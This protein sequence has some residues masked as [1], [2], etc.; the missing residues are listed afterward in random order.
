MLF[1]QFSD[2]RTVFNELA[3]EIL[4]L[5]AAA[6]YNGVIQHVVQVLELGNNNTIFKNL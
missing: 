3:S 6:P 5:K 2:V 4:N 1:A